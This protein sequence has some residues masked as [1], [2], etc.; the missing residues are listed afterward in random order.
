MSY[1]KK[2]IKKVHTEGT[3]EF[4]GKN[5]SSTKEGFTFNKAPINKG[6]AKEHVKNLMQDGKDLASVAGK[7]RGA[8]ISKLY[9]DEN[10]VDEMKIIAGEDFDSDLEPKEVNSDG[11][12]KNKRDSK[13][14]RKAST[15]LGGRTGIDV[16]IAPTANKIGKLVSNF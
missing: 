16:G 10:E 13:A 3:Q 1:K 11:E 7:K 6:L 2:S 8:F 5:Q 15:K 4:F 9:A 12:E 14:S